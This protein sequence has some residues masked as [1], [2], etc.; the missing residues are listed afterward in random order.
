M[1]KCG[2]DYADIGQ[3][4][5]EKQFKE[6]ALRS[7]LAEPKSS[8][9]NSFPSPPPKSSSLRYK[10]QHGRSSLSATRCKS[11]NSNTDEVFRKH[12]Y[13]GPPSCHSPALRRATT[14][15]KAAVATAPS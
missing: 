9:S 1:L 12:R 11:N 8:D 7:W 10:V 2:R 14:I 6:P 15:G 4:Q 3:E 5:H 13:C